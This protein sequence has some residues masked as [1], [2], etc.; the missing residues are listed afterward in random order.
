MSATLDAKRALYHDLK[1]PLAAIVGYARLLLRSPDG[2]LSPRQRSYVEGILS[3]CRIESHLLDNMRL[4]E[5]MA[6]DSVEPGA[7]GGRMPEILERVSQGM[8]RAFQSKG[9]RIVTEARETD[10]ARG[11]EVI[12]RVVANLLLAAL[13]TADADSEIA[14]KA[15]HLDGDIQIVLTAPGATGPGLGGGLELIEAWTRSLGGSCDFAPGRLSVRIP[16]AVFR[17]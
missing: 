13:H 11:A 6:S 1:S 2:E 15:E 3:A 12:E 7:E 5:R 17:S 10:L 14:L 16:D 8:E 4:A 9:A